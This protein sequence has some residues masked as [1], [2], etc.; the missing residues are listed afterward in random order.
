[1]FNEKPTIKD[2]RK[3][4]LVRLSLINCCLLLNNFY[5]IFV[6]K[7]KHVYYA[8]TLLNKT[9]LLILFLLT[10]KNTKIFLLVILK[11]IYNLIKKY[12]FIE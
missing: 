8:Y 3:L 1:M 11:L 6:V 12:F 2:Q 5:Q 10:T 7:I 4:F 9:T